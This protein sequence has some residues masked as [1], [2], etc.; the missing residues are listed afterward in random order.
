MMF[1]K[2]S[3]LLSLARHFQKM[4][5]ESN[6]STLINQAVNGDESSVE[7]LLDFILENEKEPP[8]TINYFAR[9]QGWVIAY[10]AEH[11]G[12]KVE[13]HDDGPE[14][15]FT[16]KDTEVGEVTLGYLYSFMYKQ[17]ENP[18]MSGKNPD[19]WAVQLDN[20]DEPYW[21]TPINNIEFIEEKNLEFRKVLQ[22]ILRLATK[23][24]ERARVVTGIVA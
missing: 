6:I 1:N 16:I 3:N 21:H 14:L 18:N 13:L 19:P 4:A 20:S 17:F 2:Y 7:V 22:K 11:L 8:F 9:H 23:I 12:I 10:L 15:I 5:S 24:H